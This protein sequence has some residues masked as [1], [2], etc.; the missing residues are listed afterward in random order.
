[1]QSDVSQILAVAPVQLDEQLWEGNF[2][3]DRTR[4]SSAYNSCSAVEMLRRCVL[5]ALLLVIVWSKLAKAWSSQRLLRDML[6]TSYMHLTISAN[7]DTSI[8]PCSLASVVSLVS[9]S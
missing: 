6:V 5:M 1:M 2:E 7:G 9:Y 8:V 3:V 4:A